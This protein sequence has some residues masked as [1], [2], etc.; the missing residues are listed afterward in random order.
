MSRKAILE[1]T[2]PDDQ[3]EY[4]YAYKG[5]EYRMV[6]HDIDQELRRQANQSDTISISSVRD[7]IRYLCDRRDVSFLSDRARDIIV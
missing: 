5:F 6:I 1:F 2:L 4:E 3:Q 7:I